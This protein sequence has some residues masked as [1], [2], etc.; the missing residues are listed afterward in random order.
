[1]KD[2]LPRAAPVAGVLFAVLM[3]GCLVIVRHAVPIDPEHPGLWLTVPWRR[4]AV[5]AAVRLTPFAGVAL[6]WFIGVLRKRLGGLEDRFLGSVF[7]GSG[8]LFVAS[9]YAASAFSGALVACVE[10]DGRQLLNAEGYRLARYLAGAFL[11][12]YAIKMAGVFVVSTSSIGLRTSFLPRWLSL[13][14]YGCAAVLLLAI[15]SWPWI[16]LA[17]PIWVLAVSLSL[18]RGGGTRSGECPAKTPAGD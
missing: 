5:L 17:F 18:F 9:L 4:D 1:M 12:I 3:G 15:T 7:L 6:L 11:N 2:S 10:N 13:A 16:S 8:L 14:G